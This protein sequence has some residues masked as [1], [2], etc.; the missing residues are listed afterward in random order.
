MTAPT[1][2]F[3]LEAAQ[4][5]AEDIINRRLC[6][7]GEEDMGPLNRLHERI[8]AALGDTPAA[9]AVKLAELGI[10]GTLPEAVQD[11]AEVYGDLTDDK[12]NALAVLLRNVCGAHSA[13]V[14]ATGAIIYWRNGDGEELAD[15]SIELPQVLCDF[16]REYED[17]RYPQL[18]TEPVPQIVTDYQNDNREGIARFEHT[19]RGPVRQVTD[20]RGHSAP[21]PDDLI[22]AIGAAGLTA[23]DFGD[24][25]LLNRDGQLWAIVHGSDYGGRYSL[26]SA[27]YGFLREL[28][29][30]NP[31]QG[32]KTFTDRNEGVR[33][34]LA[35]VDT[36][37]ML[38]EQLPD[39]RWRRGPLTNDSQYPR[40]AT[41]TLLAALAAGITLDQMGG[42]F[43]PVEVYRNGA[44]VATAGAVAPA[45]GSL[46]WES[47][48]T[49]GR[50]LTAP[51]MDDV[52]TATFE[53]LNPA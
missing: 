26:W 38:T 52:L 36:P 24:Q 46:G 6:G 53:A 50:T 25:V 11:G 51:N 44:L 33:Y 12:G 23:E 49:D 17:F 31:Y 30:M 37:R 22:D 42:P 32:L 18:Y 41:D 48:L 29:P 40:I 14:F 10:K 28:L 20:R 45:G 4:A 7:P 3:D 21:M 8:F 13:S 19:T 27:E 43:N 35:N 47:E 5:I 9:V 34:V 2:P 1:T 15:E 16:Q 39:G